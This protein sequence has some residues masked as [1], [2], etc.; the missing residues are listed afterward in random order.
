LLSCE[1]VKRLASFFQVHDWTFTHFQ[2]PEHGEWFGWLNRD[3]TPSRR[4]KGSLFKGPFNLPRMLL[5]EWKELSEE[6]ISRRGKKH[7]ST[8]TR[9]GRLKSKAEPG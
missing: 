1:L 2:D 4:A 5:L 3:G 7:A 8:F 6:C 9:D